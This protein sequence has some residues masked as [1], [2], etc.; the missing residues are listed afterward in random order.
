MQQSKAITQNVPG[1]KG[2]LLFGH[3]G[4]YRDDAIGF[5]QEMFE[6]YGD[7]VAIRFANIKAYLMR[8]PDHIHQVLV[9]EASK[10]HKS[11]VYRMV[12]GRFLGEGLVT[13]EGS[14]WRRQRAM[15]QPAFHTKRIQNYADVMVNYTE[16]L[17]D[18]YEAGQVRNINQDMMRLTLNIVSK[19][20]FDAEMDA[21]AARVNEALTAV[22]HA[23]NEI[24]NSGFIIPQWVPTPRN[25]RVKSSVRE[26]DAIMNQIITERRVTM[27]DKG[28]LLSMLLL[29]EDADGERMTD[30]QVRDEAV[31][32]FLA[33][34]ETTANALTWTWY[35]LSQNPDVEA[36]LHE[37]VDRVLG[38]RLPIL[39]DMRQLEYTEM[40]LKE[41]MRLYPPVP[42]FGRQ[43]IEDVQIG[44][45]NVE[46]DRVIMISPV[47][48]HTDPRWWNDPMEFRPERFAKGSEEPRHKH[49]YLPFGG[50]PRVCIGNNFAMME[51]VLVMAAMA[52]RYQMR[53]IDDNPVV[54]KPT[55]TLR[56]EHP[57]H[58]R[59][60]V[61]QPKMVSTVQSGEFETVQG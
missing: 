51:G 20:L 34:H 42:N 36:K 60:E 19:T 22:L 24:I 39:A 1:P 4:N 10:F 37:E 56:P 50:G 14:F 52:Q 15:T 54:P 7:V 5:E 9:S 47:N 16:R 27:E 38:G 25:R 29:T 45:I 28:D 58:M 18:E 49:A 33:G 30:K 31:T 48:M 26:F 44:D 2:N 53:F 8:H 32:L 55:I 41:S 61:R 21:N 6:R 23:S 13:S 57:M 17:L 3:A 35:L 43:A 46:K 40:V 12:L 11:P 59:I